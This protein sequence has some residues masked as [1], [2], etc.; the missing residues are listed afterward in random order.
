MASLTRLS[1]IKF[2]ELL[3]VCVLIGLH[4]HSF[5]A[6]VVHT[7]MITMGTFGGYLIILVGLFAGSLMGTP[8]NRRVDL[9]FALIG[10]ALF[11]VAGALNIELFQNMYRSSFRDT[12]LAKGSISIIEGAIFLVDAF[13]TFRGEA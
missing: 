11:I 6:G 2:L 12:G 9:F 13:L 8:V 10:C 3:I 4:Y 1:I 5:K 7:A